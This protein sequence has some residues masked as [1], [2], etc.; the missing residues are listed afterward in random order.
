M[1]VGGGAE[2]Q[3]SMGHGQQHSTAVPQADDS[4]WV[5]GVPKNT[6]LRL[7]VLNL[8]PLYNRCLTQDLHRINS[9]RVLLSHQDDGS[10]TALA[11][12]F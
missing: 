4:Q 10:K 6:T 9:A 3:V 2:A 7:G 5:L 11:N 1:L 8:L 12:D